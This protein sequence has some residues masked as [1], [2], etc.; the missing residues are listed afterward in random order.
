[1]KK[2][3]LFRYSSYYPDGGARD[4]VSDFDSLADAQTAA[5]DTAGARPDQNFQIVTYS[6][7]VIVLQGRT[8]DEDRIRWD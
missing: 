7:L 6:D 5:E 3:L 1:M 8:R 2:Y 4:F